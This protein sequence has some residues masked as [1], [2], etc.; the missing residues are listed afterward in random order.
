MSMGNRFQ[1]AIAAF[2][3]AAL[4]S[5]VAHEAF[6]TPI[7]Y[8]EQVIAT[9]S[10]GGVGFSNANV[11]ITMDADTSNITHFAGA[12]DNTGS[13]VTVSINGGAPATITDPFHAFDITNPSLVNTSCTIACAGFG[14]LNGPPF[15]VLSL[16]QNPVLS[17]YFLDTAIGPVSGG[18]DGFFYPST[19]ATSGGAF[20]LNGVVDRCSTFQ[21]G[22][23][24]PSMTTPN[25]AAAV[26]EPSSLPLLGAGLLALVFIRRRS[27]IQTRLPSLVTA[28]ARD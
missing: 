16:T 19:L 2:A 12:Y 21:A 7:I 1:R 27:Q 5:T 25:C 22:F 17:S 9:G 23:T 20:R 14:G 28:R 26:T 10:L 3:I 13:L 11:L 6:A 24:A 8:S 15:F 4:A 18:P